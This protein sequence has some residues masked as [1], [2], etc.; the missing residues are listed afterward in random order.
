MG[1]EII[2]IRTRCL[3]H[4]SVEKKN[5]RHFFKEMCQSMFD[6]VINIK[7]FRICTVVGNVNRAYQNL[8]PKCKEGNKVNYVQYHCSSLSLNSSRFILIN[9]CLLSLFFNFKCFFS[10]RKTYGT[11]ETHIICNVNVQ[12]L[13]IIFI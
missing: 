3:C 12:F 13:Q 10:N 11:S 7:K 1:K 5:S 6:K 4:F 8:F 9:E 2:H